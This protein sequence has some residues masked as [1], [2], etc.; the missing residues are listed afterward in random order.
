MV[1][2]PLYAEQRMNAVV[3]SENVG[4]A[5]RLRVRPNGELVGREEIAAAVR[6]LM[7]GEDGRAVRR[8]T[9]DLQQAADLAWAPDG[10]S[11]R[12]LQEVVRRWKVGAV[13]SS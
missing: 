4:V 13:G 2:W 1:A 6:E 3:L 12:T 7:E 5:L 9:G 8:R 10:S 11:R